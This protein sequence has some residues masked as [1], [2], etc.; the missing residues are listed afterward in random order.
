[1]NKTVLVTGASGLI[2]KPLAEQLLNRGYT[3][4]Q[5]GRGSKPVLPGVKTFT[6]DV[7]A[8]RIDPACI[9]NVD[10]IINLAGEGIADK[11]WTA[12]RKQQVIRS[13][14]GAIKLLHDVLRDSPGHK[15][16]SFITASA[17][18]H[19]GTRGD[20]ILTEESEPGTD[21][22]ANTCLAWERAADRVGELGISVAKM[23][24]GIV[25]SKDGGALPKIAQPI[26]LG[27][28]AALGSGKQWMPWIHIDDLVNMFVFALENDL[29]GVY[30]AAAPNP[31]TNKDFTRVLANQLKRPLILPAVPAIALRIALGE[32]RAVVL[33]SNRTSANKIK[34]DGFLFRYDDLAEALKE[35]YA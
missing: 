27:V 31:A 34:E 14:T 11:P 2:G 29:A 13:R 8:Q 26:K 25:L 5:L 6:W 24:I 18:G 10:A 9:E 30:N 20:E 16:K 15:V 4:F 28:G 33:N 7:D 35:I 21:F 12:K 22:L 3:V 19:Y 17:V 1:M 23:R 32:M